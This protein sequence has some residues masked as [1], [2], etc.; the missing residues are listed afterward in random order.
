MFNKHHMGNFRNPHM[1]NYGGPFGP[2]PYFTYG[3]HGRLSGTPR[4][5]WGYPLKL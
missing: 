5:T 3:D 2:D 4:K 1:D